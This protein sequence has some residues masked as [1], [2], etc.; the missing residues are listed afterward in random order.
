MLL[1]C[2]IHVHGL[3]KGTAEETSAALHSI[4]TIRGSRSY[5]NTAQSLK[6]SYTQMGCRKNYCTLL[7]FESTYFLSKYLPY[8]SIGCL[9]AYQSS[10]FMHSTKRNY[11]LW[12]I[13]SSTLALFSVGSSFVTRR[14]KTHFKVTI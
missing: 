2:N 9:L 10:Y 7:Q 4:L 5:Y 1:E 13:L 8:K 14:E 12:S 6:L 3:R 11:F